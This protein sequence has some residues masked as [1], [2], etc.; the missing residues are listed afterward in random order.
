MLG[1]PLK[2]RRK[3][4]ERLV[5]KAGI[6]EHLALSA[7]TLDRRTAAK[8]LEASGGET[9]GVVAKPLDTP[10]APGERTMVKV[11]RIRTADCVVG[12]FRYASGKREVGSL[13]LGLYDAAGMLHH[14]GFTSNIPA[15]ERPPLTR[16]LEKMRAPPGFTGKAPGGPSRWSTARSSEWE[17]LKPDVVVEVRYDHVGGDRF[18]H[19][20]GFVRWRPDKSPRQCTFEQIRPGKRRIS[21]G[22][23]R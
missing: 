14:V 1:E 16:R 13:L 20:T 8:W 5:S 19:G 23:R 7:V 4:L 12:G 22:S 21:R 18:R 11:K 2:V 10:Y 3:A 15:A 17:P 6:P 9:D